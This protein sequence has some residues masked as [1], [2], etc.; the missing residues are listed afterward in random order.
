[1]N[2]A[3]WTDTPFDDADAFLDFQLAHVLAHDRIAQVLY[4]GSGFYQ[5]YPLYD[6]NH[7]DAGWKL[8][9]QTE[10]ESIFTLLQ[11]DGLPDLTTVDFDKRDEFE[12]WM[13]LHQQVHE[14]I[15]NA[16]GIV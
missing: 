5:T 2:I 1:M 9:H 16:L 13:L 7:G 6:E 8:D 3:V 10:H 15:N 4:S 11:M 14:R 12:N